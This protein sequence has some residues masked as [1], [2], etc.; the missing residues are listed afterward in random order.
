MAD[1]FSFEFAPPQE[2]TFDFQMP[3]K[4]EEPV[5]EIPAKKSTDLFANVAGLA[6]GA[7][8]FVGGVPAFI[9]TAVGAGGQAIKDVV[10]GEDP[11]TVLGGLGAAMEETNIANHLPEKTLKELRNTYGYDIGNAPM[12]AIGMIFEGLGKIGG[13]GSALLGAEKDTTEKV[14]AYTQLAAMALGLKAPAGKKFAGTP[15]DYFQL[16]DTILKG[17]PAWDAASAKARET[18]KEETPPTTT[19]TPKPATFDFQFEGGQEPLGGTSDIAGPI[20]DRASM[21]PGV[22]EKPLELF[23]TDQWTRPPE[24]VG[25]A[26]GEPPIPFETRPGELLKAAETPGF[27]RSAEE[28]MKARELEKSTKLNPTENYETPTGEAR[29]REKQAYDEAKGSYE[30]MAP[31]LERDVTPLSAET[32]RRAEDQ[33]SRSP[34]AKY[35]EYIP[36]ELAR[37]LRTYDRLTN[38]KTPAQF[39]KMEKSVMEN[40]LNHAL[41]F[42]Y[43]IPDQKIVQTNGHTRVASAVKH[44]LSE[45]PA[46]V[47]VSDKP[48]IGDEAKMSMNTPRTPDLTGKKFVKF[49]ELG[50]TDARPVAPQAGRPRVPLKQRGAIGDW[51]KVP[52]GQRGIFGGQASKTADLQNLKRAKKQEQMGWSK[53]KIYDNTGWFRGMEG[54]WRYEIS[55]KDAIIT[56]NIQR[57][58]SAPGSK[59]N[60]FMHPA[61][62]FKEQELQ[63]ILFHDRL[64]AAYPELRKIPVKSTGFNLGLQGAFDQKSKKM[65]LSSGRESDVRGTSLHEVQHAIQGIENFANGGNVEQFLSKEIKEQKKEV[66]EQTT[67]L[68]NNI[69]KVAPDS[70]YPALGGAHTLA[71]AGN[72]N[73]FDPRLPG[74]NTELTTRQR[75]ALAK[76]SEK[77]LLDPLLELVEKKLA[78][79]EA[80]SKGYDQYKRIQ[81]EVEARAVQTRHETKETGRPPSHYP[82][83][84]YD[85]PVDKTIRPVVLPKSQRGAIG[86]WDARQMRLDP[87]EEVK[88]AIPKQGAMESVKEAKHQ[89]DV[90]RRPLEQVL[91]EEPSLS[92]PKLVEDISQTFLKASNVLIDKTMSILTQSTK[93]AGTIL[94]WV[95]DQRR[96]ISRRRDIAIE[97]AFKGTQFSSG[98]GLMGILSRGFEH[99]VWGEDGIFT[100]WNKAKLGELADFTKTWLDSVGKEVTP[101]FKSERGQKIYD[102]VQKNFDKALLYVNEQRAKSGLD[103]IKKIANYFPGIRLGDYRV[104]VKDGKGEVIGYFGRNNVYEAN[105]LVK[106]LRE[107][108]KDMGVEVSDPYHIDK[109]KYD[110]ADTSMYEEAIRVM[111]QDSEATKALQQAY[112]R[113]VGKRGFG[114]HGIMRRGVL[115]ALGMEEGKAGVE[116]TKKAVEYYIKKAYNYGANL[117]KAQVQS[118]LAAMPLELRKKMPNALEYAKEYLDMARGAELG[119]KNW[120]TELTEYLSRG[121]GFGESGY[122][123]LFNELS[124]YL[125]VSWLATPKFISQQF[126]QATNAWA[127]TVQEYGILKGSESL[128]AGY[129]KAILPD[130][131]AKNAVNWAARNEYMTPAVVEL[132][133]LKT[134]DMLTPGSKFVRGLSGATLGLVE[135]EAVRIP[136]FLAFEHGLRDTIKDPVARYTRAAEMMDYYM[137]HYDAESTPRIYNKAGV[138][139]DLARPM[140]QYSHNAFGQFAEYSQ[141][142]KQGD[143]RPLA[144][145]MGTQALVGG[146]RGTILMAEAGVLVTLYNLVSGSNIPT[147]DEWLVSSGMSDSL[148]YGGM[149]NLTGQDISRSVGAPDMPSMFSLPVVDFVGKPLLAYMKYFQHKLTGVDTEADAMAAMKAIAPQAMQAWVDELFA[150]GNIT[151]GGAEFPV[152]IPSDKMRHNYVRDSNEQFVDKWFGGKSIDESKANALARYAK[153]DL[154]N[155]ANKKMGVLNAMADRVINGQDLSEELV[156]KYVEQGGDIRSLNQNLKAAIKANEL[157]YFQRQ[158]NVRTKSPAQA[159]KLDTIKEELDAKHR[160]DQEQMLRRQDYTPAGGPS[161][162]M[163]TTEGLKNKA[164]ALPEEDRSAFVEKIKEVQRARGVYIPK[165]FDP[166]LGISHD[167]DKTYWERKEKLRKGRT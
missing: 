167:V 73:Q 102:L 108:T 52:K 34:Q 145:F 164:L 132:V 12:K 68:H 19:G 113:V 148:V 71:R 82:W 49:S 117:E 126:A 29:L 30:K 119:G 103:P 32:V 159:K 128:L 152:P 121:S 104:S 105:S 89:F 114:K 16:H 24:M 112:A 2:E 157:D 139:G 42:T 21:P 138:V 39:L 66:E 62:M 59:E 78:I 7:S 36:V 17:T 87:V 4:Q 150:T 100:H 91:K 142:A 51:K 101:T 146:I 160:L 99:R 3:G 58:T 23:T 6:Q 57:V 72:R 10:S 13:W 140:K 1:K 127:K 141:Q 15:K 137:V 20:K 136:A 166:D 67:R 40:G 9:G 65:W 97:D 41:E 98:K 144:T 61:D 161:K 47:K 74:A 94:K 130:Q 53:E 25:H 107:E 63:T 50:Y 38:P 155:L 115:G 37:E 151:V 158:E 22:T 93:G 11:R 48:F 156:Q 110:V 69:D 95:V 76:V 60:P 64:Y 143:I 75:D 135:R 43:S 163:Y 131:G 54:E 122:R 85:V 83:D 134:Q 33:V 35:S 5:S 96:E 129:V 46:Y 125:T 116:N 86:D 18:Y 154:M 77:G 120:A 81:G 124:G 79:E 111:S 153:Q 80:E 44:G 31:V 165:Q 109:S 26:Q 28:V 149:S 84:D 92:D 106:R 133:S 14:D 162:N 45:I 70:Y 90:D 147:P 88:K 118:Q 55:D 8:E 123:R 27:Q 56:P